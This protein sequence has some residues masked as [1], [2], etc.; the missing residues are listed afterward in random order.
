MALELLSQS[1]TFEN[2][3]ECSKT[4]LAS[5]S[6]QNA[7]KHGAKRHKSNAPIHTAS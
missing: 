2:P 1:C 6:R 4:S 7:E 5:D 3:A